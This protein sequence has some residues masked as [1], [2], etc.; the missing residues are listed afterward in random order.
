[1]PGH[2]IKIGW[3]KIHFSA[4]GRQMIM[5]MCSSLLCR[6]QPPHL[7]HR[8]RGL[9]AA[10][11]SLG[12]FQLCFQVCSAAPPP[13]LCK[14]R[15]ESGITL[16]SRRARWTVIHPASHPRLGL[17][18]P[19]QGCLMRSG[20]TATWRCLLNMQL[21][22]HDACEHKAPPSPRSK[23]KEKNICV[24]DTCE[25]QA[26]WMA[27]KTVSALLLRSINRSVP[28]WDTS[29]IIYLHFYTHGLSQQA[30]P[31]AAAQNIGERLISGQSEESGPFQHVLPNLSSVSKSIWMC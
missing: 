4:D 13:P 15:G 8:W 23:E 17:E 27:A 9:T 31:R 21:L 28:V 18:E 30:S 11:I 6:L 20:A 2:Y 5:K 12:A 24:R 7:W 19:K 29:T 22:N 10:F 1:M 26:E 3:R 16:H 25:I 14:A